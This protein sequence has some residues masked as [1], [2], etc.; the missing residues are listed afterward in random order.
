QRHVGDGLQLQEELGL[1]AGL[2]EQ[3]EPG[4]LALRAG[5]GGAAEPAG[6][7][8]GGHVPGADADEVD[9]DLAGL[10]V[11]DHG[12]VRDREDEVL[13][14]RPVLVRSHARP[15]VAGPP[16]RAAVV[17]EQGGRARVHLEDHVTAAAAVAAVGPAERPVLLPVDGGAAVAAV[18]RLDVHHDAV[19]EFGHQLLSLQRKTMRRIERPIRLIG[20]RQLPG[21]S[22]RDRDDAHGT[23]AALV[24]ELHVTGYQREQRVV[25]AAP[26][27]VTRVEVRATLA[28]EDLT[29]VHELTTEALHTVALGDLI[30]A[31]PG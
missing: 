16:V 5:Q 17:V 14:A 3:R 9:Q 27:V 20:T 22:L 26:D 4:R 31:V 12:A 25:A 2:A 10:G 29:G 11:L 18:T 8:P 6:A 7:A 21:G 15:A 28:H 30:A 1:L 19:H 24:A 13:T 23:T